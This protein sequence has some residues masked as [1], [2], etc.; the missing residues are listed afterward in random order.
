MSMLRLT[1]AGRPTFAV[2]SNSRVLRGEERWVRTGIIAVGYLMSGVSKMYSVDS[3][4][5]MIVSTKTLSPYA[6]LSSLLSNANH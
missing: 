1:T 6:V 3:W 4:F 2:I 5:E